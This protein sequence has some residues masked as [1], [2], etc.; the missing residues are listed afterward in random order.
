MSE[1]I[2]WLNHKGV[3]ILLNDY[4]GLEGENLLKQIDISVLY[5]NQTKKDDL[6]LLIDILNIEV[7]KESQLKFA[8]AGKQ[9]KKQCK[10]IAVIGLTPVK[11]NIVNIINK[12]TGLGAVGMKTEIMAKN[13]LVSNQ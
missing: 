11:R 1:R 8:E 6:L 5:I 9:I 7:S 12:I 4:N 3:K 13:W 2:R 10:K